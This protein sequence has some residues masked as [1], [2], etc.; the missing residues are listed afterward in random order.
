MQFLAFVF[1]AIM[2]R[3]VLALP[4]AEVSNTVTA[5][6]AFST[7]ASLPTPMIFA[8]IAWDVE[9]RQVAS[10]SPIFAKDQWEAQEDSRADVAAAAPTSPIL[11]ANAEQTEYDLCLCAQYILCIILMHISSI[12]SV[13]S[14][15]P[16]SLIFA[17]EAWEFNEKR[18]GSFL[19]AIIS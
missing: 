5:A 8:K 18:D 4:F 3:N 1:M 16:T 12:I 13:S 2:A 19:L 17:K 11:A 15:S 6:E 7:Q 10:A 14:A 9:K